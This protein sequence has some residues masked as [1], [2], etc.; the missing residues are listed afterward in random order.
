MGGEL[1]VFRIQR[2]NDQA[3][4][5]AGLSVQTGILDGDADAD[6]DGEIASV[7]V[8]PDQLAVRRPAPD[9]PWLVHANHAVTR[10]IEIKDIPHDAVF[11]RWY[12][13]TL[14]GLPVQESSLRRHERAGQRWGA[15]AQ[16]HAGYGQ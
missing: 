16:S 4:Y 6:A 14:R 11:S 3:Q 5:A 12:P 13:K 2:S 7:E 9:R 15:P 10:E 8:A 1:A